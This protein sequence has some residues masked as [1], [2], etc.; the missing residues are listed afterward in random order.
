MYKY[1]INNEKSYRVYS[2][3]RVELDYKTMTK[4]AKKITTFENTETHV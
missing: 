2:L 1:I 3:S 4:T